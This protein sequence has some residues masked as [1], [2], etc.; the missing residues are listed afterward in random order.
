[1]LR[2]GEEHNGEAFNIGASTEYSVLQITDFILEYLNKPKSLIKHVEDR[3]GH[4]KRHAVNTDKIRAA[5]GWRARFD[6]D[7]AMRRTV[8]WYVDNELWWR[9][10][11]EKQEDYK[12]FMEK[13]YE[14]R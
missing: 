2:A 10:I 14:N 7:E 13:Y 5:L 4:V 6:F 9:R 12:K 8:Q 11:K 1:M 3:L